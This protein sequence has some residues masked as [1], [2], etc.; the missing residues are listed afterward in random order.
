[1]NSNSV[2]VLPLPLLTALLCG[3]VA[4]MMLRLDLG[5]KISKLFFF[6]LFVLFSVEA[7]LVGLRFGYDITGFIPIQ[8]VLPFLAGPL[9]YL[10][11]ASLAVPKD[12][13]G[14]TIMLHLGTAF[15]LMILFFAVLRPFDGLD[16]SIAAS[17][18]TYAILLWRLWRKGADHLIHARLDVAT[19]I[20]R[21]CLSAAGLLV[22]L[23]IMDSVI[24][25]NFAL[26]QGAQTSALISFGSVLL[27]LV[28]LAI[29]L[30]LPRLQERGAP[31]PQST[32]KPDASILDV[33]QD[34]RAFLNST[35]LYLDPDLSVQRLAKRMHLPVRSLSAAINQSQGMNVSQYVNSFRLDHA[36]R[37]LRDSS[38]SVIEIMSASGFLTRSNFYREFQ[39]V[40]GQTPSEFRKH[41][42]G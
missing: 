29:L 9:M 34:V 24:A 2:L 12:V 17:Y 33:E 8:R 32:P 6:A 42:K 19:L 31:T 10:G 11:F 16:L 7:V 36:A 20:N 26:N 13:F 1:M 40:Y 5:P 30:A 4:V 39:R 14:K 41:P 28:L 22:A 37:L 25:L 21:W 23:L 35:E 38:D 27:I 18:V 15:V 3:A